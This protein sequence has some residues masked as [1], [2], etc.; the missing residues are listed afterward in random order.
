MFEDTISVIITSS[1]IPSH[2]STRIIDETIQSIRVHL[3]DVKIYAMLDGLRPENHNRDGD[4]R[5][6]T[7]RMMRRMFTREDDDQLLVIPCID[8][9]HQANIAMRCLDRLVKTPQVLFVEHDTPLMDQRR[10]EWDYLVASIEDGSTNHIRL[11]YDESIHPE[12][13]HMMC[14][15]LSPYLIKTLQWHQRPHLANAAWYLQTLMDN[16]TP[17]SRSW[18]E[19]KM[20]SPVSIS[21]WEQYRLTV[22]D[23]DGTGTYMKR[24]RD[25]DG[26]AGDT[27][28]D[29]VF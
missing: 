19:D 28:F 16:F 22:Y 17:E 6:Y 13:Q 1:V 14:G 27:K 12:H 5:E 20:H 3:P 11:H 15:R 29:P 18:I 21:P 4:Y 25:L 10:I 23:P 26:R 2:P 8:F 7:R 9:M 24:S